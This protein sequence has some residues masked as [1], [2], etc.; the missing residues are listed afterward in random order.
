MTASSGARR[1]LIIGG[2]VGGLCAAIA[3]RRKGIEAIV[4]ER[5][6]MLGD[7]G[8]GLLLWAN[9]VRVLRELGVADAVMRDGSVLEH[10]QVRSSDGR[11]L[12]VSAPGE[13][14]KTFGVPSL[15]IHRA[16][17]HRALLSA[18]PEDAV[19]LGAACTSVT[20]D[21]GGV[22]AV[23]A[24]GHEE[25][26]DF[27]VGADGIRSVVRRQLFPDVALR[28]SGYIAWR[29]AV[30]T[31][32][33]AT[34][35]LSSE[36]WGRGHRFG[37][38]RLDAERVY[39]FA[40]ANRPAGMTRTPGQHKADL[41]EIFGGWHHPVRHLLERTAPE[42][43][44]YNDIH[45]IPPM[46]RWSA[47]L[48]TLLGDAAH[49][50][51]PNLGQGACMAIESAYVLADSVAAGSRDLPS[52]LLAYENR[53]R[54]RTAFVTNQS[55]RIGSV[56]QWENPLACAVRNFVTKT[57]SAGAM[58]AQLASVVGGGPV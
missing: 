53:R 50:T 10:G 17:L 39:W 19:R 37:V 22:T 32:D 24:D 29:G 33:E 26:A 42:A 2:G 48:V 23:F 16:A 8:A 36:T 28:Y 5:A 7:V 14:Q 4:H 54:E 3:L 41:L 27:L 45:D 31:R 55:W 13:L 18:L 30:T 51:T 12:A 46:K 49:A 44:L 56:A 6:G 1:A 25:R 43:I 15:A 47:G 58:K 11:V 40:T 38:L 35:G 21:E 52:A 9:A 34:I 20:Q 57:F